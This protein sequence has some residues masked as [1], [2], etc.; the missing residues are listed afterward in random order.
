MH[1]RAGAVQGVA[2]VAGLLIAGLVAGALG[3]GPVLVAQGAGQLGG[4]RG[5]SCWSLCKTDR[6]AS[7]RLGRRLTAHT[8]PIRVEWIR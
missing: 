4:G 1:A 8:M 2:I 3:I 6:A 7:A 5:R